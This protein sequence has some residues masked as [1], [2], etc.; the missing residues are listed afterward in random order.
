MAISTNSIIHYTDKLDSL[1]AII[2]EGFKVRFCSELMQSPGW[3]VNVMVP[4]VSFCDIP[5]SSFQDHIEA[6]GSYGI[7]LS[8][9]WAFRMG[10]NPVLYLSKGSSLTRQYLDYMAETIK[11]KTKADIKALDFMKQ[12]IIYAKNYQA[13][14]ERKDTVIENYRFYNEREWR[15]ILQSHSKKKVS[16]VFGGNMAEK[17][18]L[19]ESIADARIGFDVDEITYIIVKTIDEIE[20]AINA[21]RSAYNDRCTSKQL[22]ILLSKIISVEQIRS[23]F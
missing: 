20:I 12:L 4:M 23:D 18:E 3:R 6:Y 17:G 19:N 8:K 7:G 2:S 16:P 10:V 5:F 1:L 11:K 14:L 15:Y 22:D 21:I 9:Q 13:D